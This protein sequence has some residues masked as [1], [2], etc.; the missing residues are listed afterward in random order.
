MELGIEK[1][2]PALQS[3]LAGES[4]AL[5]GKFEYN[6]RQYRL[7]VGVHQGGFSPSYYVYIYDRGPVQK[8]EAV[9]VKVKTKENYAYARKKA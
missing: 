2:L 1:I 7:T 4:T 8:T 9:P 6:G 3:V 5:K